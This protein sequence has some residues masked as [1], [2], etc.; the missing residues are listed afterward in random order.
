MITGLPKWQVAL[1]ICIGAAVISAPLVAVAQAEWLNIWALWAV[2]MLLL[3]GVVYGVLHWVVYR[4]LM[5]I[6]QTMLRIQE[7]RLPDRP[8]H[9]NPDPLRG[10]NRTM[11]MLSGEMRDEIEVLRSTEELRREF[12]GSVSHELKTPIFA[13]QGFI[14]TLLDGAMDDPKVN[15]KFLKQALRNTHRLNAL[16]QDLL[17]VTSLEAGQLEM[18]KLPFVAHELV[19]DIIQDQTKHAAKAGIEVTLSVQAPGEE[20]T[21]VLA[22]KE[23]IR[24]V[25]TNLV[26]NAVK[27]SQKTDPESGPALVEVTLKRHNGH[28]EFSVSDNGPGIPAESLPHIFERFYRVDK[29]RSRASG[30]TGLGLSIVKN[31]LQAHGADIQVVS[32]PG[33]TR[34]SFRLPVEERSR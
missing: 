9:R 27:Y 24:Q 15:R 34:F 18:N 4:R 13:V 2:G 12:L 11:L 28:M 10:I 20:K 21:Y 8:V 23:R 32:A 30:G 14:E 6:Y 16:V 29:S 19:L 17:V 31:L 7:H 33:A 5:Q 1:V 25:L 22:D 3:Y 26:D